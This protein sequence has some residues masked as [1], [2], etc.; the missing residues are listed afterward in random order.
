MSPKSR[1]FLKTLCPFPLTGVTDEQ[2]GDVIDAW[3]AD[4][5]AS[6]DHRHVQSWTDN[7]EIAR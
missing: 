2:L 1:T 5:F 6:D 4:E 3:L 7:E